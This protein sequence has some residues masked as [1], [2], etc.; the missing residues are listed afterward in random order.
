[1][2]FRMSESK[3]KIDLDMKASYWKK[4]TQIRSECNVLDILFDIKTC[5]FYNVFG[6]YSI[7]SEENG[8]YCP[9]E[10]ISTVPSA[11]LFKIE[12]YHSFMEIWRWPLHKGIVL[13]WGKMEK[14]YPYMNN[15]G[16]VLCKMLLFVSIEN[17]R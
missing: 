6:Q 12:N 9:I 16:M 17:Q 10:I 5:L 8:V 2:V 7:L 3:E 13:M 1:M 11:S 15:Y 4:K 14:Y